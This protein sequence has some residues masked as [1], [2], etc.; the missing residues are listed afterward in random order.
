MTRSC[1]KCAGELLPASRGVSK[2]SS[3]AGMFIPSQLVPF[4]DDEES[5]VRPSESHDARGGRCP[6]DGTILSRA[7]IALD[8]GAVHLERCSSCRG[9]WFDHGEWTLLAERQLLENIDQFWTAEWRAG[10]RRLCSAREYERR[11][12]EEFGPEL[13]AQ[14]QG[15]A[16]KLKG[17]ERRSQ[18]L[19]F[20][21]D[22]SAD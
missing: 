3:C 14:L 19:A 13:Y 4:V 20:L 21:R 2:C 18:A 8:D 15:V 12:R 22:A 16:A 9:V 11:Q 7:E 1:P 5:G 6:A 10:Q 17:Y